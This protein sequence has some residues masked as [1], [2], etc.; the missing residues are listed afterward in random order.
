MKKID[1]ICTIC[2]FGIIILSFLDLKIL[3]QEPVPVIC[4]GMMFYI[5]YYRIKQTEK[6]NT[7]A[8]SNIFI[9]FLFIFS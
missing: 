3:G 7:L 9:A 5:S 2:L 4:L 8:K 1:L 6:L